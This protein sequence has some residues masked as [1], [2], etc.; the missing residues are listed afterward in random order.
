M[1]D[2][3]SASPTLLSS[4]PRRGFSPGSKATIIDK[5]FSSILRISRQNE[6]QSLPNFV[7]KTVILADKIF[8]Y[9][10]SNLDRAGT[11]EANAL[12]R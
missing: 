6:H 12:F 1:I 2:Y 9:G 11:F 8:Y 5:A 3:A 7:I 10:V 4:H